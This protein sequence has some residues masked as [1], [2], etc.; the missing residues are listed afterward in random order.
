MVK[1]G[2]RVREIMTRK[3]VTINKEASIATAAKIMTQNRVGS[4]IIIDKGK[5]SGIITEGDILRRAFIKNKSPTKT[6]VWQIMTKDV[7]TAHPD[8]DLYH[9]TQIM[10]NK[11]IRRLPVVENE[12]VV[13]YITEKDLLKI[14]PSLLDVLI[15]KLKI[16]EPNVKLS[17]TLRR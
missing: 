3:P 6:K 1:Y 13:G 5:L 10:N 7:V 17:Y 16:K 2:I 4:L 12:K 15:E 9:L 11:G 14:E 8:D